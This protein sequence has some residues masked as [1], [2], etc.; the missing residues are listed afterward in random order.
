MKY[1]GNYIESVYL[2]HIYIFNFSSD[3]YISIN[4]LKINVGL[5]ILLCIL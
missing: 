3:L 5:F 2:P 4:I 1:F